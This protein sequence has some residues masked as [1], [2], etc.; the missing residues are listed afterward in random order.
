MCLAR[1]G[2]GETGR[3]AYE[4][5]S[6]RA[7]RSAR[8]RE[9]HG[10]GRPHPRRRRDP[11]PDAGDDVTTGDWRARSLD[12]PFGFGLISRLF[13]GISKP[14]KTILGTEIAG[15]VEAVGRAVERFKVGDAVFAYSGAGMGCHAEY[16][17]MPEGGPVAA[18]AAQP[19]IRGSRRAFLW[20]VDGAGLLQEREAPE[21]R[22]GP[23][24]RRFRGSGYGRGATRSTPRGRC[25]RGL[26]HANVELVRS[27]G[28]RDVIDYTR[29]DFTRNGQRYDVI[30]DIAGT[31]PFAR[32][33]GSLAE[34]GR[35]LLVLGGV[36]GPAPGPLG[37]DDEPEADRGRTGGGAA[38][39]SAR[40]R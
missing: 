15:D 33:K 36:A 6:L 1:S 17:C 2:P 12:V 19:R 3:T 4:S 40:P 34:D 22:E 29:E 32:S 30:V 8:G 9:D 18:E 25:H 31:A 35:L 23:R 38:G 39:R 13:F 5:S 16:R 10:G 11:D 37:V 7:I 28:A 20:R 24:Q 14:R 21:G 26:Q 27:L